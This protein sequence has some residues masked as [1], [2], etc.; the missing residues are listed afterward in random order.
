M[1]VKIVDLTI[2]KTADDEYFEFS[3]AGEVWN[4]ALLAV[5]EV[6]PEARSYDR[7]TQR[8]RVA[9]AF[10]HILDQTFPNFAGAL[11]AI[12]SQLSMF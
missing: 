4:E 12:R 6:P 8:W 1:P 10:E 11:D 5:K 3:W 9:V 2:V 7:E